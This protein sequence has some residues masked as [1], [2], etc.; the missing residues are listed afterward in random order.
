MS[1]VASDVTAVVH[2]TFRIERSYP[3]PASRV[4]AA[5]ADR[6][7]KLRWFAEGEGW[8]IQE[9]AIDFRVGGRESARFRFKGTMEMRNDTVYQDIVPDRR[10][11]FA[12]TMTM[13]EQRISASLGTVELT[14]SGDGTRLAYTE[15]AAFFEGGDGPQVREQGWRALFER[16]DAELRSFR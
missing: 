3:V 16:L 2:S 5:F 15:Q 9:F 14:P 8:E 10:I 12:Y 13:G 4:F 11:V 7:T 6:A 1:N